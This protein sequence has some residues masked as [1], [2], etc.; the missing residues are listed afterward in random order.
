MCDHFTVPGTSCMFAVVIVVVVYV[1]VFPLLLVC[2]KLQESLLPFL[3]LTVAQPSAGWVLSR[4]L[5]MI[6]LL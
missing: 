1:R 6:I 3:V 5:L 4:C 2:R